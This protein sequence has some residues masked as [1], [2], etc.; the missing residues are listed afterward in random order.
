MKLAIISVCLCF[1]AA[2]ASAIVTLGPSN[3]NFGLTGIGGNSQ[4]EGQSKMSWGSCAFD[5]TNTNCTISGI[6]SGFGS[7][8]MYSFVVSYA[9]NGP[10]PLNAV[11]ISPGNDLFS[12]TAT[13]NFSIVITLTQNNGPV[14]HFYD[15]ANFNFFFSSPACTG[16]PAASCGVGQVG[17]TPG[18]TMLDRS[19]AR[20]I[21]RR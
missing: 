4:G 13:G 7:G 9:G 12:A 8:G 19:P 3:Q 15:F 20:S 16:V 1:L 10:F 17:L 2:P 14:L 18:A 21:R 11:S 6:Y 5:G